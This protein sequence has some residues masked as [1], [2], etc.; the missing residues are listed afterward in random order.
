MQIPGG[1][2]L[3]MVKGQ[4]LRIGLQRRI[5]VLQEQ[6][7]L[8]GA[9]VQGQIQR[10]DG[11]AVQNAPVGQLLHHAAQGV[12]AAG[13]V[14]TAEQ[15]QVPGPGGIPGVP[16]HKRTAKCL[17]QR[18][19][20]GILAQ[21][22]GF[23]LVGHPGKIR[24]NRFSRSGIR[25]RHRATQQAVLLQRTGQLTAHAAYLGGGFP[26]GTLHRLHR[27]VGRSVPFLGRG[28]GVQLSLHL[29]HGILG[30]RGLAGVVGVFPAAHQTADPGVVLILKTHLG[31]PFRCGAA[32]R[33]KNP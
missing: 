22:L 24:S 7:F 9:G 32:S 20:E 30:C 27:G 2:T 13:T 3:I 18:C 23:D 16:Q 12:V 5:Q 31:P 8:G 14:R 21:H 10:L 15:H 28:Q 6:F 33:Y 19:H 4:D 11:G 17:D 29:L 1:T 26:P 25:G